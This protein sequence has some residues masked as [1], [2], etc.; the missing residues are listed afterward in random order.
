[1]KKA[2]AVVMVFGALFLQGCAVWWA[3]KYTHPG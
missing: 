3:W 2:L 1:M